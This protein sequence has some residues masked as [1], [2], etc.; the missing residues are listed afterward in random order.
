MSKQTFIPKEIII[1]QTKLQ[2]QAELD[3]LETVIKGKKK[4]VVKNIEWTVDGL[5]IIY[6]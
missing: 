3:K 4:K 5:I 6:E 1:E 2:M